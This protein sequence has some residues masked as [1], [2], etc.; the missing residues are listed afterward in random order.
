MGLGLVN[1]WEKR[2]HGQ[3]LSKGAVSRLD[4][5]WTWR[6]PG[7][8]IKRKWHAWVVDPAA[9]DTIRFD[10]ISGVTS[11][12]EA[13]TEWVHLIYAYLVKAWRPWSSD[14]KGFYL[15]ID[16]NSN[17][18][19]FS[20][21]FISDESWFVIGDLIPIRVMHIR[22]PRQTEK[23]IGVFVCGLITL[24]L[25]TRKIWLSEELLLSETCIE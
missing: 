17:E 13:P 21:Y 7:K 6:L 3:D 18:S 23:V 25:Q 14:K 15:Y 19:W 24:T 11:R 4:R 1:S 9:S 8:L 10:A 12:S 22:K 20:S 16:S 2:W 5:V